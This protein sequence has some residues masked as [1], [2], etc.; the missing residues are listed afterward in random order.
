MS[1]H[2]DVEADHF[3]GFQFYRTVRKAQAGLALHFGQN[4]YSHDYGQPFP[5]LA[6]PAEQSAWTKIGR[7]AEVV[8]FSPNVPQYGALDMGFRV[9]LASLV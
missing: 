5:N 1:S 6:N 8:Q 2:H 4:G 7:H 9:W 3:L